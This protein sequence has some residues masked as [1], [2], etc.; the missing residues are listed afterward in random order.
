M[1]EWLIG[2]TLNDL[3]QVAEE[4]SLPKYA[5]LQ[6]AQWLYLK[7]VTSIDQ[8]T[9]LSK[10]ARMALDQKYQTGG[11]EPSFMQ[12][13]A[14]GTRKYLFPLL[15]TP[16]D[17]A[18][19]AV[20][21][22]GIEAVMIPSVSEQ[23]KAD[24]PRA[25]LC[26]SSQMG[27]QMGCRFCMT[28]RM[29]FRAHLSAGEIMGQFLRVEESEELTNVVFMGMGEPL[30]NWEQVSKALSIF[31]E[32]WGL[33]W[34][35]RRITLS[36]VGILPVIDSFMT[37]TQVHLAV[38]LHN[39]FDAQRA[40]LM[41][42]QKAYPIS[43]VIQKLRTYDFHGQRRLSFEYILFDGWNDTPAH[44]KALLQLLRGMECRV[45]LI[46]FHAIDD[47][48]P[49]PSSAQAIEAFKDRLNR[50]GLLTTLRASRGQDIFAAC[51]LL[52]GQTDPE[53]K[54]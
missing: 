6:M 43:E 33:A 13:S 12:Q 24:S 21:A 34:S 28:A 7:R 40:E 51:G 23:E 1:K 10:S 25:T 19:G 32:P 45:N 18:A 9:N 50:G 22:H 39:P 15:G 47:F 41:P 54:E 38:S 2:K 30:N 16:S 27:C 49:K 8:M 5:A 14:D 52:S 17:R 26:M 37:T 20:E 53:A 4:L 31:T 48:P 36:T 3:R 44:A 46:R 29:G 11:F 35:P 42:V